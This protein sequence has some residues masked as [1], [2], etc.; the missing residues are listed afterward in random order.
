MLIQKYIFVPDYSLHE[1]SMKM[2][3]H[4]Q[5]MTDSDGC[6]N[7]RIPCLTDRQAS[8]TFKNEYS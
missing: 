4:I 1:M 5:L 3:R 7:E 2:N 6:R 8:D